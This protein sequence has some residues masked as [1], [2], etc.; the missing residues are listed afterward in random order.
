M[1]QINLEQEVWNEAQVAALLGLSE[2]KEQ[3]DPQLR[4]LR[5][6][7]LPCVVLAKGKRVY[8]A[9]DLLAYLKQLAKNQGADG[10]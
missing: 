9:K 4:N 5:S 8:L 10:Q 1:E 6:K 3:Y 2:E 7:G